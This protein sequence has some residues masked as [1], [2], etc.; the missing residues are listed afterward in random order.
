[1]ILIDKMKELKYTLIADGSSDKTL[2]RIIKWLLDDLYPKMPTE[3]VL[4]DF[5]GLP[6]PPKT[7]NEKLNAAK[8]F[9][10][11]DII[12]IHRDAES[13]STKAIQQRLTEIGKEIGEVEFNKSVCIIPI[14][15]METWLLI[16]V[17]AIKKAAG[18]RNFQGIINLP[19]IKKLEK[20]QQPKKLLHDLLKESCGLKGRNL[21]NFNENKAIHLVAENIQDYS[22]LRNLEA[23]RCFE[24]NL[25]T[26]MNLYF[27]DKTE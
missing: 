23:F 11:Y 17:E 14:K 6:Q 2:L 19:N 1:L 4:A 22:I 18:N 16:D 7:L 21:K 12:F 15:M 10:P 8:R 13:V 9:F 3:G 25:T 24:K 26:V 27:K 20:E 5:R